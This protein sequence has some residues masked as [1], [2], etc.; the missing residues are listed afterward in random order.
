MPPNDSP[1]L[2]ES[3]L[4]F[5]A[6]ESPTQPDLAPLAGLT[7][8]ALSTLIAI[9]EERDSA[10]HLQLVSGLGA[11]TGGTRREARQALWR[12]QNRGVVPTPTPTPTQKASPSRVAAG[13][14]AVPLDGL[15]LASPPGLFGRFWLLLGTLPGADA[16]EVKGGDGASV[17][18]IE[19]LRDISPSRIRRLAAEFARHDVRGRPV[20]IRAGTALRLI[21]AWSEA[22]RGHPHPRW[23][24]VEAWAEAA[25]AAGATAIGSSAR[26]SIGHLADT[27]PVDQL[28]ALRDGGIHLPAPA[29]IRAVLDRF[30]ALVDQPPT[31]PGDVDVLAMRFGEDELARWLDDRTQR[32]R[33]KLAVEATAD[34]LSD[35]RSYEAARGFLGLADKIQAATT[36]R[37][38]A[39]EPFFQAVLQAL[40]QG[41]YADEVKTTPRGQP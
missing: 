11:A 35:A 14:Q 29:V 8:G 22:Q 10:D 12:L 13:R 38:L 16:L 32:E 4:A 20:P 25:R 39:R 33:L 23:R 40:F 34:V 36:G 7:P 30:Q 15:C 37:K 1:T 21:D 24:A 3:A 26:D 27:M 19:M 6:L 17:E 41:E 18:E 9:L 5:V 31:N 28:Q 2:P